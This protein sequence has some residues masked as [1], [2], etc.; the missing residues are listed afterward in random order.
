MWPAD[1]STAL[2]AVKS[3]CINSLLLC[4]YYLIAPLNADTEYVL[5]I[6]VSEALELLLFLGANVFISPYFLQTSSY[7]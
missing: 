6:S 4:N 5:R 2:S 1:Y 7:K 3:R